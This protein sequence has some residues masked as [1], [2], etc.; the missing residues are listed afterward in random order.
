V[1]NF[2]EEHFTAWTRDLQKLFIDKSIA[3]GQQISTWL[4]AGNAA[5]LVIAF[6]AV[7]QGSTCEIGMIREATW[8]FA[9]GLGLAFAANIASY[10]GALGSL[11][12]L[13]HVNTLAEAM[14]VNQFHIREFEA[15]KAPTDFHQT[16]YDEAGGKLADA[17]Q[18]WMWLGPMVS[19]LLF[20]GSI[21]CFASGATMPFRGAGDRLAACAK[22]STAAATATLAP[23]PARR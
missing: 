20:S 13:T 11:R 21:I 23:S 5:A 6:N 10:F 1:S 15:L 3:H 16:Q 19:L 12:F 9:G 14:Y 17:K 22:Q 4:V 7:I 8:W 18:R 2:P